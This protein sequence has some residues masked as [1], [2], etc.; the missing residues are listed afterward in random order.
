MLGAGRAR[1]GDGSQ[2]LAVR[3]QPTPTAVL[4]VAAFGAF[5]AFLDS[6]I[7]NIAFPDIR[8][9]FPETSLSSL[10][11]V[12]NAYNIVLASF[13][14][15]AGRFS[16][17]LGRRK[18]FINGVVLFTLASVLCAVAGSVGQLIAFRVLQGIGAALLIPA[19]LALVVE[20]FEL[21]RR[22]HGVG[23]WG[24]AAAIA[25]GLGPPIGGSLVALS[26]WRLA[27]LVNLPL[28]IVAVVVARRQL[29]ESRSPGVRRMPDLRGALL[30]GAGLGL[31]T[32][33]LVKGPDWGWTDPR[34]IGG[35]VLS[36]VLI[37]GFVASSRVHRSPLIDPALVRIRSFAMGN[38]L[39]V[40]AGT[41]FYAYLLTHVF[42]L[43]YVWGYSLLRAGLAVAPAAFVAAVV[44]SRLGAVADRRGHRLVLVP[45]ALIWAGSLVWYLERVGTQPAFLTEWLPGQIIQGIGVGATLPVLGSA[46]LARLPKNG[47]YAT[48]S[49]VVTSA[50]QLGAVLGVALLVVIIGTPT[51]LQL[52]DALRGGWLFAALCLAAVAVGSLFI[53]RTAQ[54][55][56][57]A[58]AVLADRPQ[59]ELPAGPVEQ[60][61]LHLGDDQGAP[62]L[63]S[64]LPL[65]AGLDAAARE[66]VDAAAEPVEVLAGE[67]LFHQGDEADGLYLV[68]SG[69][70]Q[71]VQG[72]VV[73]TELSRGAV[74]G[75]LALL[76]GERRSA[77]VV[78]VRD[79][80]L[81][82][83]TG[84][85][86]TAI[87]DAGV[88]RSLARGLAT[89]LQQIE[90]P[91]RSSTRAADSVVAVVGVAAGAPV[92]DVAAALVTALRLHLRV[93]APDRVDRA[94][95]ERAELD[96]DKVVLAAGHDDGEWREFCLRVA[97]R[98]VLV[99][100]GPTPPEQPLPERLTGADLVLTGPPAGRE[101]RAAWHAL[102]GP[103]S[104]HT[105]GAGDP[106]S[107]LR[108]L[109]ARLAGRSVGLVLGGGGA[110][111]F[112]HLGVID[113]LEAA[114]VVVD[115]FAGTSIGAAM[116]AVAATGRDA[117]GVDAMA[118]EYF[119]RH[120]PLGDWALPT[121][122]LIRGRRAESLLHHA[123]GDM[124]I[125][126]L[127]LE[128]RCVSVD[129]FSRQKV[130]HSSG[131]VDETVAASM[132]LPGLFPP[133]RLDGRL[134]VDGGV[135]DNLPVTALDRA[136]GPI[137][138]SAIGLGGPDGAPG[139]ALRTP[140]LGDTLMRAM[141][142][143][144][145][146]AGREA[147]ALADIV[148][149]PDT[150]GVGLTEWHQIDRVRE[151]G[152]AT[153]R[154]AMPAIVE[155]LS[156]G[157]V[158]RRRADAVR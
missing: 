33:G 87:A 74:L 32:T 52:V 126:Q 107:N 70:L 16:D 62:G 132:R 92:D 158:A 148:L 146:D 29:V 11:W 9:T 79:S 94:G 57:E 142:L 48:A 73:L 19:S 83:M 7:V 50:R 147:T 21:S 121:R 31:L 135:L 106:S 129:L 103:T 58:A 24:A 43:D 55:A 23:L 85:A 2:H 82:R 36:V 15:A 10:S 54:D 25:S 80:R 128:F 37:G 64:D 3:R 49:A 139:R 120:N 98:V 110:R 8:A 152:R 17:L 134:H 97:D 99:T 111:G 41:G 44:A 61:V 115:R 18:T 101:A 26:S 65:F 150:R 14:V 140:A 118:Y 4:L 93:A 151:S 131:R 124:L 156:Q 34:V 38:V 63:L 141:T 75:E 117:A 46:A 133:Y 114:G 137:I 144:S 60:P 28:G 95:L 143:A 153:A 112:A 88:M 149:R 5:L 40:V 69:R 84:E 138:A 90:P 35:F 122:S 13:L 67:A 22:A 39:S 30:L 104:V 59:V 100:A 91:T 45:G 116:A 42:Y 108:G 125:E 113:E 68:Q 145:G 27:F 86:F 96:A 76:T 66:A 72:D 154:A 71:V 130:V 1:N 12:L 119:V 155:L 123:F 47:G 157:R 56:T 136:E 105:L 78:A 109:A 53:G 20:A 81:E 102:I 51:P 89:R 77:T 6:T 127:P